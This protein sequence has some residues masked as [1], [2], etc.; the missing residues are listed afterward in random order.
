MCCSKVATWL[1][2]PSMSIYFLELCPPPPRFPLWTRHEMI[3][4][5]TCFMFMTS[6]LR[7]HHATFVF[8]HLSH[9]TCTQVRAQ[10]H[11][12][13][14]YTIIQ[15]RRKA[16][17]EIFQLVC[18]NNTFLTISMPT[19]IAHGLYKYDSLLLLGTG[20]KPAVLAELSETQASNLGRAPKFGKN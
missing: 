14:Q 13:T 3:Q 12:R 16:P 9:Q 18:F 7:T 11:T 10:T 20:P 17:C 15:R 4:H 19:F 8:M 2:G 5:L 1:A 6:S